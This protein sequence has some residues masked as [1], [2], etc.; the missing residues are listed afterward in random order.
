MGLGRSCEWSLISPP[1]T[2]TGSEAEVSLL[3]LL[4]GPKNMPRPTYTV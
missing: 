1:D 2:P 4:R 3:N